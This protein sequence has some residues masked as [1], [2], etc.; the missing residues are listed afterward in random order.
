MTIQRTLSI[1][2]PDAVRKN[3]IGA[4]IARFEAA[5]LHVIAAKMEKLTPE[6]AREFYKVH[7]DKPFFGT[8]VEFICSGP[9]FIQV[10]EG[11][12][13]V[14]LNRD[15]MG[16]TDPQHA[17]PRTIRA[18]FAESIDQN[19]VHGSDSLVTASWEINFF[20]KEDQCFSREI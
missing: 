16:A 17:A 13:A 8:L 4:I 10:L 5:G 20:F 12:H 2:K 6:Q 9:V 11:V 3:H 19:A 15:L 7:A 1:I 18:D 14:Q